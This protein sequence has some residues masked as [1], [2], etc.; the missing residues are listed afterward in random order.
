MVHG[1]PMDDS[2]VFLTDGY[3]VSIDGCSVVLDVS[4]HTSAPK[5]FG[6]VPFLKLI[7]ERK[8]RLAGLASSKLRS[9]PSHMTSTQAEE[10]EEAPKIQIWLCSRSAHTHTHTHTHTHFKRTFQTPFTSLFITYTFRIPPLLPQLITH[11]TFQDATTQR[12]LK[13]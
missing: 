1:L 2:R 4:T 12:K 7:G 6:P 10:A 5:I 9:R 3:D 13:R 8:N 11:I